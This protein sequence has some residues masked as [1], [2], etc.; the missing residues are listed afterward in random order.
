MALV[1]NVHS[2]DHIASLLRL[3]EEVETAISQTSADSTN[4]RLVVFGGAESHLLAAELAAANVG[5]VLAPMLSYAATWD[6]RRALTGAPLTNGTAIDVLHAAGVKVAIGSLTEQI[7]NLFLDA[8]IARVNGGGNISEEDA[9]AFVSS[10]IYNM[11][12]LKESSESSRREFVVFEGSPLE[13]DG[14]V[15]VVADGRGKVKLWT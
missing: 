1:I 12:G 15:R 11:L 8:G 3:K 2:A 6:Q 10:N 9:L 4:L 14:R 5:V 13:I 7:R